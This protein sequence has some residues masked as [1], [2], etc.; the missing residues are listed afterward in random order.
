MGHTPTYLAL[1]CF[2]EHEQFTPQSAS[3]VSARPLESPSHLNV[4]H[5]T[6]PLYF[7]NS[8]DWLQSKYISSVRRAKSYMQ[9]IVSA[10]TEHIL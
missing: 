5:S 4:D 1:V 6:F 3:A 2:H 9:C 7:A 10:Q 8:Y